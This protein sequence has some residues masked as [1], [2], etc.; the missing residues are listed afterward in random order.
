MVYEHSVDTCVSGVRFSS[1]PPE[2]TLDNKLYFVKISLSVNAVQLV[3]IRD[4]KATRKGGFLIA[5]LNI[6]D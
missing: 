3:T 6:T 4:K 5:I 1:G 2:N